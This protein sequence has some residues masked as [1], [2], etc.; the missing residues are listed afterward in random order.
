M[1][2]PKNIIKSIAVI[3]LTAVLF[4]C[5]KKIEE[6][7]RL[8]K[9]NETIPIS[10]T[11][12]FKLTYTLSGDKVMIMTSPLMVDYTNLKKFPY[13]YFPNKFKI[14]IINTGHNDKTIITADKAFVYKNPELAELIGNV[15]IKGADNSSLETNHLYWDA[16]NKHI[17]GEEQTTIRQ[18]DEYISGIGFD[19]S[20]DF[21]N[22]RI[23]K[24][25]GILKVKDS[26]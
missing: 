6:V 4:S 2:S 24:I 20:L 3:I 16:N 13:Q 10:E 18:N 17:F 12:N 9:K 1:F 5:S 25:N 15:R 23:N 21:K 22:V 7:N 26:I 11:K 14:V 19:S 8:Y